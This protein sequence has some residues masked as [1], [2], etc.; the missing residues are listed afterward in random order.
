VLPLILGSLP[1]VAVLLL[2]APYLWPLDRAPTSAFSD[3]HHYHAPMMELL[4]TGLRRDGELPRWNMQDFAGMPTLG[5]PQAQMYNPLHWLLFVRP[6]LH[7]FGPLI[8][9]YALAGAAGFVLFARALGLS[10]ASAAAGAVAFTLGGALLLHLVLP[11]HTVFAPFFLVPLLLTRLHRLAHAPRPAGIAGGA[12]LVGL[13]AVSLHPQLLL[14]GGCMIAA[15][16]A[17]TVRRAPHPRHALA[18]VAA[19]AVLGLALAA[20]HLLPIGVFASEF[21]RGRPALFD[22]TEAAEDASRDA[23]WFANVVSG[24]GATPGTDMN[25]ET[26]YYLGAVALALV[27][28]GLFA[29][30]RGHERRRLVWLYGTIAAA[31]LLFGLGRAG[32]IAPWLG[33]LPGFAYFRIPAR[34][35]VLLGL[36]IALLIALGVEALARAPVRRCR[37]TAGAGCALAL[38]LL[39]ATRTD[40]V[41]VLALASGIAGGACMIGAGDRRAGAGALLVVAALALDTG[42][43]VAPY[44]ETAAET[45]IGRLARG[46][47]LPDEIGD[48]IR[49][50]E[51]ERGAVAPGIPELAVRRHGVETLAGFNPLIPWRFVLY[52]SYAAGFDPFRYHFDVAVPLLAREEP[53]LFDLLGVT[54]V[55]HPPS[56]T[57]RGWRWK[58][59]AGAL[60]RAYLV[61]GPLVVPEGEGDALIPREVDALERL[62]TLDPHTHVLLHGPVAEAALAVSGVGPGAA[63]EAYRPV[64]LAARTAN[65]LALDVHLE[66][67]GILVLN[68]PFFPGWRASDGAHPVPILRANVLFRALVLGPGEHHITLEFAPPAWRAGW[69]ISLGAAAVTLIFAAAP[70]VVRT[71]PVAA[72]TGTWSWWFAWRAIVEVF[73]PARAFSLRS[74]CCRGCAAMP[75][76]S[77][78]RPRATSA[79]SCASASRRGAP[80]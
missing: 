11:G 66:R 68:E 74:E 45:T 60:P 42:A 54:H 78:W 61:P 36:P 56:G 41:H 76:A 55:L 28:T 77:A 30:P 12:A 73:R 58:R 2:L 37:V 44:V 32:D 65:R 64:P 31:L 34:A 10:V 16:S 63:L 48:A 50:A 27:L 19:A 15:V 59:S 39:A 79:T 3:I 47:V 20:V 23:G 4:A 18:A 69:W 33:R 8:V 13:L 5:D 21:S 24:R 57:A 75:S 80:T 22:A 1:F 40:G 51:L 35:F 52:A 7:A 70:I 46:V 49:I 72:E 53:V 29:W 25:W 9:A 62:A 26:H 43:I 67:P 14:Y 6:S 71:L 17:A 38:A